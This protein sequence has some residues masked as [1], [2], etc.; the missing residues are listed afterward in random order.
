MAIYRLNSKIQ[1]YPW[2]SLRKLS[3]LLGRSPS[4]LPE[5]ELWMG[6]HPACPSGVIGDPGGASNLLQLL[7]REPKLAGGGL[8][9]LFKVLSAG[10]PLSL[11]CHPNSVQAEHGFARENELGIALDAPERNYKDPRHK[12]ELLM[13][14]TDFSAFCGFLPYERMIARFQH[15]RID[16]LLPAFRPFEKQPDEHTLSELFASLF[17]A[18]KGERER[19]IRRV[20]GR[21]R[22]DVEDQNTRARLGEWLI[23]LEQQYG[24]D[25]GV[26]AAILLHFVQLR[27]GEALFLPCGVLHSYL[28]GTGLEI[29]AASDNVL[30]G[31]LTKKH[32]D[33][34]ELRSALDF[35]PYD[36]TLARTKTVQHQP[37]ANITT[38]ITPSVDFQLS[39]I[40]ITT[41]AKYVSSGPDILLGLDGSIQVTSQGESQDLRK[42][43]QMFCSAGE[44]YSVTGSARF[45]KASVN[46]KSAFR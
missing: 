26:L 32:V 22:L 45:A 9:Y 31:G 21:A 2:G 6:A 14:L 20:I 7:E 24:G 43:E 27:P 17:D 23:K 13:A 16:E 40:N 29:M 19:A 25:P 35:R 37:G 4:G 34:P 33:V 44:P 39:I 5:A 18:P 8:P 28:G 38:F 12:P 46:Q 1:N 15:Y 11:Q 41:G 3:Q 10:Q 30:R 36:L 42:G